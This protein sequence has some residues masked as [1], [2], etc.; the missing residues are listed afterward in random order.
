M[1]S[2]LLLWTFAAALPTPSAARDTPKQ[3]LV[4]YSFGREYFDEFAEEL[5]N[6][7]ARLSSEQVE[8][9]EVSLETARFAGDE[10][11]AP[12]VDYL[13]ALIA[14][15]P[16]DLVISVAGPAAR[17]CVKYRDELFPTTPLVLGS[18]ERRVLRNT[19]SA[20]LTA[21]VPVVIDFTT[22][23]ENILRVAPGTTEIVV[24]LGGS[25]ISRFW[26]QETQREFQG[27]WS[28]V[29]FSWLQGLPLETMRDRVAA[30]PP[31]TVILFGEYGDSGGSVRGQ[32]HALTS[33]H[34]VASAPIFGLFTTQLGK[35]IVGGPL[36]SDQEAS[37]E[38][39]ST[40][41]RI[42]NGEALETIEEKPVVAGSPMYDFRE[43]ERWGIEESLLPSGSTVLFRP[44]SLWREYRGPLAIGLGI[45]ALQTALIGGLLLQ[46][47]RRRAAQEETREL[48]RRLLTA[49]EDERRRLARELHDDLSQRLA[50]LSI[51]AAGMERS[52]PDDAGKNS[53]R[54]MRADLVRLSDDVHALSY[55][56]HPS[57]LDDL[58]LSEALRVECEQFSRRE[59]IRA[60]L[61][62]FDAPSELPPEAAVCLFRIA[63]EALRNAARHS[64]ANGIRI[65]VATAGRGVRMTVSDDG[66]GFD[67]SQARIRRSL[68]HAGMRERARLVG[69]TVAVESAPG[70]G[71]TVTVSVPYRK[72][73][74]S[75]LGMPS[76]PPF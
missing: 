51:D 23:V 32:D 21:A 36:I 75:G 29:R 16:L 41:H 57:V 38:T 50:R 3:V 33:L 12:F 37:R 64:R 67:P 74:P 69:G 17:F 9:F 7:L 31:H 66:V 65:A 71:T 53:A 35:G 19:P 55:Q 4:L 27:F 2:P 48:A 6:E 40:A 39:A 70:R 5:R 56:L 47:S 14:E 22:A 58:G 1:G 20:R 25:A 43:L 72:P 62:S 59:S 42:L 11:E 60:E 15:R 8:L 28:R 49:Q 76:P 13:R 68:G 73:G 10:T 63:Q 34:E 45:V 61:T 26:L 18:L 44:P 24:V 54:S 52:L 30:L 46:R